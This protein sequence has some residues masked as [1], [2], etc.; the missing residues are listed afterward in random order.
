AARPKG[1]EGGLGYDVTLRDALGA[2]EDRIA[3]DFAD[4]PTIEAAVRNALGISYVYLGEPEKAIRH[5]ERARALRTATPGADHRDTLASMDNLAIAFADAGR[6]DDA[7]ALDEQSLRLHTAKL[8][9]DHPETLI[10]MNN[11]ATAYQAAGR[12]DE[13]LALHEREL[14][15]SR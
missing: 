15:L 8:G 11:L 7:I 9:P 4:Q 5:Y 14:E 1:Q 2:A 13:A 10:S 3:A 6:I 12:I